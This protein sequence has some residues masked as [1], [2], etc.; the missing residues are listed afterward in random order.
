MNRDQ[1]INDIL[2]SV[3]KTELPQF[4]LLKIFD[5]SKEEN[6]GNVPYIYIYNPTDSSVPPEP[7][8][9]GASN[10]YIIT[11]DLIVYVGFKCDNDIAKQGIYQEAYW[12]LAGRIEKVFRGYRFE[13]YEELGVETCYIRQLDYLGKTILNPNNGK[14]VG[15]A[16]LHFQTTVIVIP[17]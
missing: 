4:N 10:D 14:G 8:N 12:E 15:L 6:Q 13:D 1:Y 17:K 16:Y 11:V 9:D 3:V 2:C 7:Y 5:K